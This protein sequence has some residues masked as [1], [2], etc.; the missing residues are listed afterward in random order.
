VI[1]ARVHFFANGSGVG[2]SSINLMGSVIRLAEQTHRC[3]NVGWRAGET[4]RMI[5][6]LDG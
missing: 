5:P 6:G 1:L 2:V 3:G 4:L